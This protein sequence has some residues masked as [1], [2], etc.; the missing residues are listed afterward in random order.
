MMGYTAASRRFCQLSTSG[1]TFSVMALIVAADTSMPYISCRLSWMSRTDKPLAYSVTI[2][3]SSSLLDVSYFFSSFGSNSPCLSRGTATSTSPPEL[4]TFL[5]YFPFRLL[6]LLR[7]L[8]RVGREYY[9]SLPPSER[10]V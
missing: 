8:D 10:H 3:S 5:L 7:P 1:Q 9:Y 4:R 6:P 2:L